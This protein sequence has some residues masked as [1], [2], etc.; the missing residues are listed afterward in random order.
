MGSGCNQDLKPPLTKVCATVLLVGWLGAVFDGKLNRAINDPR[1]C[2]ALQGADTMNNATCDPVDEV[3]NS[4]NLIYFLHCVVANSLPCLF[5]FGLQ[6]TVYCMGG[7]VKQA[8]CATSLLQ[9]N[10]GLSR[11]P[12]TPNGTTPVPPEVTARHTTH[13]EVT[14][15][16]QGHTFPMRLWDID[17]HLY[18]FNTHMHNLC[19]FSSHIYAPEVVHLRA[20]QFAN[21]QRTC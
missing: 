3:L 19:R 2:L 5:C 17:E 8:I 4:H 6:Y 10:S 1:L 9:R 7:S 18:R 14:D 11:L 13:V 16:R 15:P 21:R 12:P 20:Q